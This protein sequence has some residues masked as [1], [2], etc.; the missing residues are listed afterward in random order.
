M[1]HCLA[2]MKA[3]LSN[4]ITAFERRGTRELRNEATKTPSYV[5]SPT[6][7]PLGWGR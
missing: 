7:A 1:P 6:Q 2:R 5:K 4:C 3:S